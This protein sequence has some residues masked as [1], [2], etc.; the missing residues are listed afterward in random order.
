LRSRAAHDLG[1]RLPIARLAAVK[2][3]GLR[4]QREVTRVVLSLSRRG[5]AKVAHGVGRAGSGDLIGGDGRLWVAD[6]PWRPRASAGNR[7]ADRPER[8]LTPRRSG[9]RS[10]PFAPRLALPPL[11]G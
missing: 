6:H 7:P 9:P 5:S 2:L 10:P 4:A 1:R 3:A 11:R 8:L